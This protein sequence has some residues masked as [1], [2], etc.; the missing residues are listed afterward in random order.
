MNKK[1]KK[2]L[3]RILVSAVLM[4]AFHFVPVQGRAAVS[5][6]HGSL[7]DRRGTTFCSRRERVFETGRSLTNVS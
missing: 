4:I 6:V 5:P 2:M 7:P 1:Q 3:I